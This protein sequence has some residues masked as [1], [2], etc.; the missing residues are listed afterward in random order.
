[1]PLILGA[2]SAVAT[3]FSVDN[4]C[5]FNDGDSPELHKTPGSAGNQDSWTFSIWLKRGA[6]GATQKIFNGKSDGSNYQ[7]FAFNTSDQLTY[8]SHFGGAS[9]GELTTNR[10]FRDVGAWYNITF[11]HD[12]GNVTAGDRLQ[13]WVNG[14][15]ETS[16]AASSFPD[17]NQDGIINASGAKLSVASN[18][19]AQ[20]F[21]GYISEVVFLDGVTASPVDTLGEFDEDSPTIWKPKDVSGLTFGT[22]GFYLDFED[23]SNLGN[24]ANGGTDL[25][26]VNLAAADQATDT[27]T[28]NFCTWNPL[29]NY[30]F[31]GTYSEGNCKVAT[32]NKS[33][34]STTMG[35]SKGKWYWEIKLVSNTGGVDDDFGFA[36]ATSYSATDDGGTTNGTY[37]YYCRAANGNIWNEG[38]TSLNV[39]TF[40]TGDIAGIAL[41]LDNMAWYIS[42]NGTWQNSG[43]PTSG[44]SKTGNVGVP[45]AVASTPNGVYMP[46]VTYLNAS[47]SGVTAAN[48]GGCSGFDVSSGNADGNGYGNME[49]SVPSGFYSLCTKNLAEFG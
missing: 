29:N 16:F 35:V 5:R 30:Y 33:W 27:S 20:Y 39:N 15:R 25:T 47:A 23:S 36:G 44:A 45:M 13:Y 3:G 8:Y 38:S 46:L 22:N 10:V 28:N 24:D 6:L 1:M 18:Q 41:D 43:D 37:V 49:Y 11:I 26:E 21:D 31:G 7:F 14:V 32:D 4:S 19:A 17:Q 2:Q 40:A 9:K 12:S 34:N 48:F 42:K